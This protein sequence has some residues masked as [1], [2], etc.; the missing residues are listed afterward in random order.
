MKR[1]TVENLKDVAPYQAL[2][3]QHGSPLLLLDCDNL[4]KQ[5]HELSSALPGVELFYAIKSL[6]HPAAIQTLEQ[7][8]AGFDIATSGEIEL[9]WDQRARPRHTIHTHPIKRDADIRDALRF[10]CTTFVV[11][12]IYELEKFIEYRHRVGLLIRV[13]FPN[14]ASPVDLSRKFGCKPEEV[15]LLLQKASNMGLHVKGLS[16]HAGSQC[17][18]PSNHVHAIQQCTQII[19]DVYNNTGKLLSILDIGGGFP[20]EYIGDACDTETFCQ[21]IREALKQ[22][23]VNVHVIAEPGRFLSASAMTTISTVM[24]KAHRG[25]S[26]WY[27]LDDG[28]YGSYSGQIYDHATY[29]L[30]IF[31]DHTEEERAVFAGPTCDSID[32][33]AENLTM[34]PLNI[35]DIVV[36]K[37]M[38]AYTSASATDFNLFKRAQIVVINQKKNNKSQNKNIA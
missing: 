3:E 13:S 30:T 38:G 9:L 6:P 8:G 11:D 23:P 7:L 18:E 12:N 19:E 2:V 24:G 5:Y 33:I 37:Q 32:V 14:P 17:P 34:P 25:D 36:G 31:S 20:V 22:L 16:F 10:G 29:P 27:Y 21:P 26:I 35:G 28:V 1:L 4:V 15:E